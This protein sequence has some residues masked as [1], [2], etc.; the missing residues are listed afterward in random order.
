[1]ITIFDEAEQ[2]V[3]LKIWVES[4]DQVEDRALQQAVNLSKLPFVCCHVALMPDVHSGFGVP[5]GTVLATEQAIIP[6]AV[7]FDIGCGIC[8]VRTDLCEGDL[9]RDHIKS[10]LDRIRKV[11]PETLSQSAAVLK[12][13][14]RQVV[15]KFDE[16]MAD[17]TSMSKAKGTLDSGNHFLELQKD[18]E[19]RLWI[20]IHAGAGSLSRQIGDFFYRTAADFCSDRTTELPSAELAYLPL[21]HPSGRDYLKAVN[22]CLESARENRMSVANVAL[23]IL[24]G[25]SVEQIDCQHNFA[26]REVHY[27]QAV[28]VHRKGAIR[29]GRGERGVIPGSMG[30]SSYIVRGKGN[31]ESFLSCSHGAGKS[32]NRNAANEITVDAVLDDLEKRGVEVSSDHL[33][34]LPK[35]SRY[36]YKDIERVMNLQSDLVE[37]EIQLT[38]IGVIRG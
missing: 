37:K 36:A 10:I 6:N 24:G 14:L 34:E 13:K 5:I 29:L 3:P 19:D 25:A 27:G 30:C 2:R 17:S 4:R 23:E 15:P 35:R 21:D 33:S 38:P 16:L 1:M 9:P 12:E 28:W 26:E 20:M 22:C 7:G 18:P 31:P 11:L 8:V 32:A